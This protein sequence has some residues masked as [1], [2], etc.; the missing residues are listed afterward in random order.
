[1]LPN[2]GVADGIFYADALN[3]SAKVSNAILKSGGDF[4]FNIKNNAG[5]KEL[6]N[7]ITAIFNREYAKGDK[8]DIVSRQHVEKGHGRIDQTTINILA[9]SKLDKRIKNEHKGV[10]TLVHYIKES[11]Y[12]I[13]GTV[14]R[15]TSNSRYY[16]SSLERTE[17]NADQILYSI[18]DYWSTEQRHRRLDDPHVFNQAPSQSATFDYTSNLIGIN[19]VA[20]NILSWIRQEMIRTS[21]KKSY[22]PSY[23]L[24]QEILAEDTVF[25]LLIHLSK[26]YMQL[27]EE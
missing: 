6:L 11:T 25:D 26:Y 5:N 7:H 9:A 24:V 2:L 4:L 16:I 13:N 3:T 20:Y 10:A 23:A 27:N 18:L 22:R 12:L 1:M 15:T 21:K 17:A 19:K 14:T 8:S